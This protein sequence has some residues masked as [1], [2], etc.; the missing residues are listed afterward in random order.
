MLFKGNALEPLTTSQRTE[1]LQ[2]GR[3][4]SLHRGQLLS[5]SANLTQYWFLLVNGVLRVEAPT[6][7]GVATTGFL[8][9]GDVVASFSLMEG[10]HYPF[11]LRAMLD[12]DVFAFPAE[13]MCRAVQENAN[14]ALSVLAH[15][16]ERLGRLHRSIGRMNTASTEQAVGR[17]LYEL[18]VMQDD[19]SAVVDKKI[20]QKDIGDALGMSRE[21]VNKVLKLLEHRGLVI[22]RDTGYLVGPEFSNSQL[23]PFDTSESEA[24]FAAQAE[25]WRQSRKKESEELKA[26]QGTDLDLTLD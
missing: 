18:S 14:F 10:K 23:T 13:D 16:V 15:K 19:G 12:S 4:V 9:K 22:R 25:L 8:K 7:D 20:T 5:Q 21:Q 3:L 24:A 2:K 1:L 17:T 6:Q 11:E 26:G